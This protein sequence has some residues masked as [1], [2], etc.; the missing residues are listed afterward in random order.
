VNAA[1]EMQGVVKSYGRLR[2]LDGLD[3]CVPQG[4][5]FGL[6]GSNGAG[7]TTALAT[8]L[9]LLRSS[10]GHINLLGDGPFRPEKHAGRVAL[11][12]QDSR[13]PPHARVEELLRFYARLQGVPSETL[14]TAIDELL[15]WV[16]LQERRRSA[17]RTLSH[18]M[19]RRVAI[20]QAFLGSPELVL[21]DEPL[22]GL[23]PK[24]AARVRDMI[25][26]R[27]SHQAIVISS[28]NLSDIEALCDRV[29]FIEKGKLVRQDTLEKIMRRAHRITYVLRGGSVPM[30][31]LSTGLPEVTW[32][33]QPDTLTA[34]FTERYT[35]EELNDAVL[36][37]LLE[38]DVGILEIRRGSD[39]ES[40]YLRLA[41][42]QPP[43]V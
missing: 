4:S 37:V 36:R 12:P 31:K 35:T 5:I 42:E 40:E 16:H 24:E 6:V 18:G 29:A 43:G 7:K 20:A 27:R 26:Q 17:V 10:G 33:Q 22:N 2:A 21:L 13:F 25:R 23:D 39:L 15:G 28:H 19:T 38:A 30:D 34:T 41:S 11:L 32:E 14:E 8:A 1:L 9:G 3:L